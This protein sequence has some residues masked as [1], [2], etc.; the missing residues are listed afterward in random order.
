MTLGERCQVTSAEPLEIK[1]ADGHHSWEWGMA[2]ILSVRRLECYI[3]S[4]MAAIELQHLHF[5]VVK[6][7]ISNVFTTEE[8]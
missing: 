2:A 1:W 6:E 7:E 8:C 4:R 3:H 5:R